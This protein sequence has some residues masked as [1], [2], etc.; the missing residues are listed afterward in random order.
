[1]HFLGQRDDVPEILRALDLSLLPS[2]E[3]PFGLVTVES[4]AVGT[5]P[6]V[7]DVG[8]GPELVDDGVTGRMLRAQATPTLWARAARGA[9][10]RP[11]RRW[12][13]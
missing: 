9:A 3:E 8:A 6:L 13:A 11:R 1:M 10:A 12:S 2:W 7:S 5:P 4:M